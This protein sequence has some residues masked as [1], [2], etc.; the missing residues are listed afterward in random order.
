MGTE[1]FWVPAVLAAASAGG[2]Y[3]NQNNANKRQQAG[4]TQSII[5]QQNL[6]GKANAQV[7]ALT[8]QIARNTPNQIQGKATGDY[9]A[10]LRKNAAGST[11]GGSTSAG[12]TTFGQPTSALAPAVGADPRYTADI[13]KS[14]KQVSDYGNTYAGEMG[15]IDSAVRQRQNEGL[16]M[17]TLG[18]NLNTLG[19]Q[20]YTTNFVDQLK[21]A[22]AG[23]SSPWVSLFTGLLG[24]GAKNYSGAGKA[25]PAAVNPML[26]PA[27]GGYNWGGAP[28]DGGNGLTGSTFGLA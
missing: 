10:A 28:L 1:E 23:Q 9:V 22:A 17:Q 3:V 25:P 12:A 7:K 21:A 11:Q 16:G 13:A 2:E 24:A 19:A 14:Q 20:S 15:A 27:G 8:D 26:M 5:D 6:E 18:T 4:E